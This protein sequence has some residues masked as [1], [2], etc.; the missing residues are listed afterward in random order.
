MRGPEGCPGGPSDGGDRARRSDDPWRD[1]SKSL[2]GL[3]LLDEIPRIRDRIDEIDQQL[4]LLL[5]DRYENARLLGRIKQARGIASRDPERERIILR[6]VQDTA[7]TLGLEPRLAL[8]IFKAIFNFSVQAQQY[9]VH[10]I[11]NGLEGK[12]VL[13]VGGTGGMGRF[14]ANFACAHAARVKIFGRTVQRTRKIAREL[15]V[16]AGSVSDVASSDIVIVAVP[17][18]SVIKTS[19]ETA[20][21]MRKGALLADLSSVKTGI[22]D[23]IFAKIPA[24]PEYVSMHPL[25]GPTV[26]HVGGQNLIVIPFRTGPQWRNFSRA[27][28]EAGATVHLMSSAYHDRVMAYVQVLHHFALLSL[29]VA[30]RKWDG[31]LKTNSIAGTLQRIGGLLTNWDTTVGIQQ[32]NPYSRNARHEFI[33][34]CKQLVGMEPVEVS[35]IERILQTSVQKWSRKL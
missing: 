35:N 4:V 17:M 20:Q 31:R 19:I 29:G 18:E 6:K 27:W 21:F 34:T 22:A 28:K 9:P 3:A 10:D 33:E 14:I 30:L 12:N 25:F 32:L 2:E 7:S 8:P 15:E 5:K 13:V 24:R 11:A 26:D 16:E 23:R 1:H